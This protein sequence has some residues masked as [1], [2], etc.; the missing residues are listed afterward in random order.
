MKIK[1]FDDLNRLETY[2]DDKKKKNI[3]IHLQSFI[4][5]EKK[6]DNGVKSYDVVDRFLVTEE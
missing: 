6:D 4:V 2:L 1:I 5:G 3:E